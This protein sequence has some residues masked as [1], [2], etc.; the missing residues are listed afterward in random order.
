LLRVL[1]RHF[2]NSGKIGATAT[3]GEPVPVSNHLLSKELSPNIH[4]ELLFLQLHAVSSGFITGH[5]TEKVSTCPSY[6]LLLQGS[7]RS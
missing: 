3:P 2:F 1:F 7:Y 5:Q 6:P 4:P